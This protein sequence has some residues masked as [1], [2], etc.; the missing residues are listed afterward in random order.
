VV[1]SNCIHVDPLFA[2]AGALDFR[3]QDISAC[4]NAGNDSLVPAGLDTDLDGSPRIQGGAV[5][6]GAY[7]KR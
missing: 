4:I 7:E 3:L 1:S 2:D 5:D 6:M